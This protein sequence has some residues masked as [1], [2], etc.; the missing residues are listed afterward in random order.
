MKPLYKFNTK[1]GTFYIA[2]SSDC[3]FHP[4]YD[5]ESLGSYAEP[6]Q[7]AA[8][9]AGGHT[10]SIPCGQDTSLLGIPKHH[11]EWESV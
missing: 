10:F 9:L 1:I 2:Q 6:W 3:R 5:N 7:A 4:L 8:D 11:S